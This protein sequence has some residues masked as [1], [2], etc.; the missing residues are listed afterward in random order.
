VRQPDSFVFVACGPARHLDRLEAAARRL[1]R[2]C[3]NPVFVVTDEARNDRQAAIA[4]KTAAHRHLP[5]GRNWCYL[6]TDVL[7]V[8]AEADQ[9]FLHHRAGGATFASDHGPLAQFSPYAVSC[10]CQSDDRRARQIE[11]LKLLRRFYTKPERSDAALGVLTR[12]QAQYLAPVDTRQQRARQSRWVRRRVGLSWIEDDLAWV[13]AA[14]NAVVCPDAVDVV[15]RRTAARWDRTEKIWRDGDGAPLFPASCRH[16]CDAIRATFGVEVDPEWQH[17]NGGVFVFDEGAFPLLDLWHEWTLG[18]FGRSPWHDRDQGTLVAAAWKLGVQDRATLPTAFNFI[19]RYLD[20]GFVPDAARGLSRDGGLTFSRPRLVHAMEGWRD[21]A[22]ELWAW[23][24][25]PPAP[26]ERAAGAASAWHRVRDWARRLRMR[27]WWDHVI[28]SCAGVGYATALLH[29]TDFSAV[30]AAV[31]PFLASAL[32]LSAFGYGLND[33][34]DVEVDRRAGKPNAMLDVTPRRRSQVLA[35][36]LVAGVLP[37]AL[38]PLTPWSASLLVLQIA[39][40]LAY[41]VPPIRL[42]GRGA[43]GLLADAAYGHVVPAL[44]A[45]SVFGALPHHRKAT[46][47]LLVPAIGCIGAKGLRNILGHQ[48]ED[49]HDDAAAAQPTFV[50][51]RGARGSARLLYAWVVPAEIALLVTTLALLLPEAPLAAGFAV[52][53]ATMLVWFR[54]WRWPRP[55]RLRWRRT[56]LFLLNVF[57]EGWVAPTALVLLAAQDRRYLLLLAVNLVL[58]PGLVRNLRSAMGRK[59]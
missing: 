28:P 55:A 36:L 38:L 26:A 18:I 40:L 25:P 57:H 37:W 47:W 43:A 24:D 41:S 9:V 39:L 8:S 35:A 45:V 5:A 1:R 21:P 4:L 3:E 34:F 29:E 7:A 59:A 42:K 32:A 53:A 16:L 13:D 33:A 17:W 19:A 58:F 31:P 20:G 56:H 48:L 44:L 22:W 6:D 49:R 50:T 15:E 14:G 12:V 52:Y 2:F 51:R 46:A 10:G 27:V 30:L 23:L 11:V 54:P